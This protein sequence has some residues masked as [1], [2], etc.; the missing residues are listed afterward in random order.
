MRILI[1]IINQLLANNTSYWKLKYVFV[2]SNNNHLS[3]HKRTEWHPMCSTII[4]I[5]PPNKN[6]VLEEI[7]VYLSYERNYYA[8]H[9]NVNKKQSINVFFRLN[10]KN[11]P[12][13][14]INDLPSE[15]KIVHKWHLWFNYIIGFGCCYDT[16][17]NI[18]DEM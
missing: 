14:Y 18:F 1:N 17:E 16:F 12:M 10:N 5:S 3:Y 15:V 8:Y 4:G 13:V 2:E 9:F 11:K 7:Y 6:Y